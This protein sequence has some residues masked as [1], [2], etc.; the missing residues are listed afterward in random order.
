MSAITR[1]TSHPTQSYFILPHLTT[2]YFVLHWIPSWLGWNPT[3]SYTGFFCQPTMSYLILP[4][5]TTSYPVLPLGASALVWGGSSTSNLLE[6]TRPTSCSY[7]SRPPT[8]SYTG[9][10]IHPT[11]SYDNLLRPTL[12]CSALLPSRPLSYSL[13]HRT[14]ECSS[15]LPDASPSYHLSYPT[16]PFFVRHW[17]VQP[18]RTISYILP[19]PPTPSPTTLF[20]PTRECSAILPYATPSWLFQPLTPTPLFCVLHWMFC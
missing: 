8:T 18:Y 16:T 20:R 12:E 10:V 2:S 4:H 3:S 15:I 11:P 19:Q 13:V 5:L 1:K 17:L 9:L 7:P 14:L 6:P